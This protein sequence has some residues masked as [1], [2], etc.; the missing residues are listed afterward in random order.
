MNAG[1][2]K[3]RRWPGPGGWKPT[4]PILE[5]ASAS[6]RRFRQSESPETSYVVPL[7]F[8][9]F[10][11][12]V[13]SQFRAFLRRFLRSFFRPRRTHPPTHFRTAKLDELVFHRLC[14]HRLCGP[15][16]LCAFEDD[17]SVLAASIFSGSSR[18]FLLA[19]AVNRSLLSF[20]LV[21]VRDKN[22]AI[23][24]DYVRKRSL[25]FRR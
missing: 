2:E 9:R 10:F 7:T 8:L 19:H 11:R 23:C 14:S 16:F 4:D 3:T 13:R 24:N 18:D 20:R 12:R 25:V 5:F 22:R 1:V 21:P 15:L 6:R 17:S